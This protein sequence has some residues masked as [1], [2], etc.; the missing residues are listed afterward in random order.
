[1]RLPPAMP[2]RVTLML[3][4]YTLFTPRHT[5]PAEPSPTG[6][7]AARLDHRLIFRH[8]SSRPPSPTPPSPA[9]ISA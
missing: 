9:T 6:P 8:H 2:L 5:L 1:M 3:A 7:L 4:I